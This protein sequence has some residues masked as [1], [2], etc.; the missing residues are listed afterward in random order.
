MR[1]ETRARGESACPVRDA[2]MGPNLS[3]NAPGPTAPT[4]R[5]AHSPKRFN[6]SWSA[7][8]GIIALAQVIDQPL[9]VRGA[10]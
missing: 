2:L 10:I 3:G 8:Q 6:S 4:F 7:G 1:S 5:E 9:P